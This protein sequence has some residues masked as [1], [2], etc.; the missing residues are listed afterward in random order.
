MASAG[1]LGF[2]VHTRE[3]VAAGG[4]RRQRRRDARIEGGAGERV[5]GVD[6]AEAG[7][8]RRNVAAGHAAG[9]P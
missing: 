2:W 4:E 1:G 5:G 8:V 7:E 9:M 3:A 6:V